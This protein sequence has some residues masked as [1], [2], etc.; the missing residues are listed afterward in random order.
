M[1]VSLDLVD[2]GVDL[3][4]LKEV[5]L[6]GLLDLALLLGHLFKQNRLGSEIL[7]FL[8]MH[9]FDHDVLLVLTR[10]EHHLI[11]LGFL[12]LGNG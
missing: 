2:D 12:S 9:S 8:F 4:L 3:V 10:A 1:I 6:P 7:H 5:L 11:H